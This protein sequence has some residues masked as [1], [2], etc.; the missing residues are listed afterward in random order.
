MRDLYARICVRGLASVYCRRRF[1]CALTKQTTCAHNVCAYMSR[2]RTIA[3]ITSEVLETSLWSPDVLK[4]SVTLLREAFHWIL[5][6]FRHLILWRSYSFTKKQ[7][8]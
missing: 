5:D 8:T 1:V 2:T 4:V 6:F 3:A 7:S